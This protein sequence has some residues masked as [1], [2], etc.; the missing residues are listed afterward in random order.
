MAVNRRPVVGLGVRKL[1]G[2]ETVSVR[3]LAPEQAWLPTMLF[4]PMHSWIIV[5]EARTLPDMSTLAGLRMVESASSVIEKK[6]M[7][8]DP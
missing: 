7:L 5:G 2:A 4:G 1:K 6:F 8:S 3:R